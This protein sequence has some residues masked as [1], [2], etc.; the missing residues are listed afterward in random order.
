VKLNQLRIFDS[1][2]RHRN[3]TNA[4]HELQMSQPGVSL[5]LKY[6]EQEFGTKLYKRG[7]HGIELTQR[8][9]NFLGAIRSVLTEVQ[10]IDLRFRNSKSG[11]ISSILTVGGSNTLSIT[12]FPRIM[13][14]F[15]KLHP[16]IKF[17]IATN[18]STEIERGVQNASIEIGLIV[19][20]KYFPNCV[21]EPHQKHE[22]VAFIPPSHPLSRKTVSLE[23]LTQY[24]LVV[25]RGSSSVSV[26]KNQGYAL[27][28]AA[29]FDSPEA[30]KAAVL[31]GLGI[32]ILFRS[33]VQSELIQ[34]D[35]QIVDCE[36][37]KNISVQSFLVY[38][39]QQELS[40]V[41]EDFFET[42]RSLKS[43]PYF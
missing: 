4:A 39:A 38:N 23:E 19:D 7:T 42:L 3:I 22:A 12:V 25:K 30:V 8:G 34:G 2:A 27:N 29:Q 31:Q 21:Y 43:Q 14:N 11:K 40:V 24:P 10:N 20:P 9:Q 36:D 5:Q 15:K 35:L 28:L 13:A 1:V 37:M 41:A 17:V 6:L 16:E 18:S 26:L 32:G 33:R